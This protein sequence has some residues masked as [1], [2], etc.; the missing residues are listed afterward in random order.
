MKMALAVGVGMLL[1]I[2]AAAQAPLGPASNP[3]REAVMIQVRCHDVHERDGADL[4]GARAWVRQATQK[5]PS[6]NELKLT[7][8]AMARVA[9][10]S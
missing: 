2:D 10:P 8:S 7:R 4:L 9:R 3:G 5:A 6:N 1:G